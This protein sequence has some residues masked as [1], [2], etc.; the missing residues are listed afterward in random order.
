MDALRCDGP[1]CATT[2]TAAL[3][4]GWLWLWQPQGGA[5][6]V[7]HFCSARCLKAWEPEG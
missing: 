7:W 3:A 1:T 6:R 5:Y 4:D 2:S